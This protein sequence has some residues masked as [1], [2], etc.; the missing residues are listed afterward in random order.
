MAPLGHGLGMGAE[1]QNEDAMTERLRDQIAQLRAITPQLHAVTDE[2]AR[3]VHIVESFLGEEC[4]L[5]L[6]ACTDFDHDFDN[7]FDFFH[8]LEYGRIDG[9]FRLIVYDVMRDPDG[10]ESPRNR[11]AW[12]NHTREVKLRTIEHIP[13]LLAKIGTKVQSTINQTRAATI[14]VGELLRDLGISEKGVKS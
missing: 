8:R 5:G 14:K 10:E 3:I 7:G 11:A 9:Q 1:T 6:T 4:K 2:A 13:D 12:I